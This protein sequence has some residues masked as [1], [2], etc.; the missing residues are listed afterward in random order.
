M[1][2][3]I[4]V[5]IFF[6]GHSPPSSVSRAPIVTREWRSAQTGKTPGLKKEVK[7]LLG[8]ILCLEKQEPHTYMASKPVRNS[9]Q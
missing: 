1:A 2:R 8:C 7:V 3:P 9:Q 4:T 5:S 6:R